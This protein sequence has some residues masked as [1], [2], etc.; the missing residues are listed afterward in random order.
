MPNEDE[1][2]W[3]MDLTSRWLFWLKTKRG[4]AYWSIYKGIPFFGGKIPESTSAAM[5]LP[6]WKS[7]HSD[8]SKTW[9]KVAAGARF[10]CSWCFPLCRIWGWIRVWSNGQQRAFNPSNKAIDSMNHSVLVKSRN[11]I[12]NSYRNETI[13]IVISKFY[14][15][16]IKHKK[17]SKKNL[18][19]TP[20]LLLPKRPSAFRPSG[21]YPTIAKPARRGM[22]P[23]RSDLPPLVGH[24]KIVEKK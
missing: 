23:W 13:P 9:R 1:E 16:Y 17:T 18:W 4:E 19:G 14:I 15:R 5:K 21:Q 12:L 10:R 7:N 22:R 24:P 3:L 6:T 11:R 8:D 2:L 20:P